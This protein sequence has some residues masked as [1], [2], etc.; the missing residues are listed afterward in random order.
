MRP[1][2]VPAVGQTGHMYFTT[3]RT[4]F[5][6]VLLVSD[7]DALAGL[8]LT[9]IDRGRSPDPTWI[10]DEGPF[11]VARE[12]LLAYFAGDRTEFD[13]PLRLDGTPFQVEVWNALRTIPYG[14]TA[15]YGQVADQIG[16]PRAVRA[17][18]SA[19]G[20]N[21]IS[22]I[23]PCHRVI[24]SDGGLGGYGWGLERKSWLLEHEQRVRAE[25][26]AG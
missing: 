4:P 11:D 9:G 3:L 1:E 15:S 14:V 25:A 5:E 26:G 24:A 22:I 23:V 6:Q 21:P 2:R 13:L 16:R 18:G 17:V 20:K 8:Y 19:N 10:L 12:Q 7:G